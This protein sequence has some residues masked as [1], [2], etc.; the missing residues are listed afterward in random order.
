MKSHT[1]AGT[2]SHRNAEGLLPSPRKQSAIPQGKKDGKSY[3]P[4]DA[5]SARARLTGATPT[6]SRHM[7]KNPKTEDVWSTPQSRTVDQER[8][9]LDHNS[10]SEADEMQ[11][12]LTALDSDETMRRKSPGPAPQAIHKGDV[13]VATSAA[14][15]GRLGKNLTYWLPDISSMVF[16]EIPQYMVNDDPQHE[17]CFLPQRL[18]MGDVRMSD[19]VPIRPLWIFFLRTTDPKMAPTFCLSHD[20]PSVNNNEQQKDF[21]LQAM[22]IKADAGYVL[23]TR[24][25]HP[26]YENASLVMALAKYCFVLYQEVQD[27]E[28]TY[29]S[30]DIPFNDSFVADL[31][32]AAARYERRENR[33][34]CNNS[35]VGVRLLQ[36]N[37]NPI[38]STPARQHASTY[39]SF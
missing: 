39:T 28:N 24:P 22:L 37:N 29:F 6:E 18:Y 7:S 26:V 21:S 20:D 19:T 10:E 30:H 14:L 31:K 35:L 17:Q 2:G 33:M 11:D 8:T 25:F 23:L 32:K 36:S 9:A 1:V 34:G 15:R 38:A 4:A 12:S 3:T 16:R 13:V 27:P 5:A